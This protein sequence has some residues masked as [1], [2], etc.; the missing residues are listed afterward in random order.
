MHFACNN[1]PTCPNP[2]PLS[3]SA[4][5]ILISL[6]S[7]W[8]SHL[9]VKVG[10]RKNW[11]ISLC[12]QQISFPLDS[13]NAHGPINLPTCTFLIIHNFPTLVARWILARTKNLDNKSDGR[14]AHWAVQ[15]LIP[16]KTWFV[17][18]FLMVLNERQHF[19][20]DRTVNV[21][22]TWT[23]RLQ[24]WRNIPTSQSTWKTT[25]HCQSNVWTEEAFLSIWC[26]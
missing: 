23:A 5:Y 15:V 3:E 6:D 24:P 9:R 4:G 2:A 7:S 1:P 13:W 21:L 11:Q 19:W 10:S 18:S 14:T 26:L 25:C 8:V 22:G 16:L 17:Q 20:Q 12:N